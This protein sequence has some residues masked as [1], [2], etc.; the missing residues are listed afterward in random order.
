[1]FVPMWVFW[2]LV[3]AAIAL[4]LLGLFCW[5]LMKEWEKGMRP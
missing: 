1:M 5:W 2:G 4:V 3:L